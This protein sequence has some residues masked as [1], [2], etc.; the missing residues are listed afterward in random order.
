MH[1]AFIGQTLNS[2]QC[3]LKHLNLHGYSLV[4]ALVTAWPLCSNHEEFILLWKTFPG[5]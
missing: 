5:P 2:K 1:D 3:Y 4:S